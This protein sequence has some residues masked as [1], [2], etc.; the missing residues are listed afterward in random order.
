MH[1]PLQ[2]VQR[3]FDVSYSC[4]TTFLLSHSFS[5]LWINKGGP[6]KEIYLAILL[7]VAPTHL[8]TFPS[9]GIAR[10]SGQERVEMALDLMVKLEA[11]G[12]LKGTWVPVCL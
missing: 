11:R 7:T 6:G 4:P 2:K 8:W 12:V 9:Q 10:L 5:R 1:C 3:C